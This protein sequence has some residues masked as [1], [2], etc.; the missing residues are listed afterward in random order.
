MALSALVIE[1]SAKVGDKASTVDDAGPASR[2]PPPCTHAGGI[3]EP[4]R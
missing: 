4:M 3:Q 2:L 1:L